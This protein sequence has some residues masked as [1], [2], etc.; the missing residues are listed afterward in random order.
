MQQVR[1]G[2]SRYSW[3][4]SAAGPPWKEWILQKIDGQEECVEENMFLM[5]GQRQASHGTLS[6]SDLVKGKKL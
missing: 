3:F 5:L 6:W 4:S 2:N 1:W